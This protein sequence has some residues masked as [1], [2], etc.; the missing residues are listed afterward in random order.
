MQG[1]LNNILVEKG[2]LELAKSYPHGHEPQA[3]FVTKQQVQCQLIDSGVLLIE[4]AERSTVSADNNHYWRHADIVISSGVHGNETAPIEIV[5]QLVAEI[6]S[7]ELA[8]A[9]RVLLIIGNLPAMI[10]STR[11]IEENM[12]RLFN[13]KHQGKEHFEAKRAADLE[14]FVCEFY[15]KANGIKLHYDL[16]T[17]IRDSKH[18]KFAIY[19]FPDGRAWDKPQLDFFAS[20][21]VPTILLGHQPSGTFSYFTSHQF[22]AH[23]FTVELGKVRPFGENNHQNFKAIKRNL[24][25]LISGRPIDCNDQQRQSM[26]IFKVKAELVKKSEQ[27]QLHLD[28][29]VANFTEYAKGERLTSDIDGG[30]VTAEDGEAIVFPNPD[31]PIGQR[32]GLLVVKTQDLT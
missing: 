28:K 12:N 16:H 23:G 26:N 1:H 6:L 32:A 3:M 5:N 8:V 7:G 2:L 20:S 18:E 22:K 14:H 21:E 29:S 30:Y 24:Q 19:P 31:V 10:K 9:N 11:F 27:F 13:G 25:S 17:A 15:K 4:P